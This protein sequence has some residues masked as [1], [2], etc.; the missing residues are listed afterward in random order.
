MTRVPLTFGDPQSS[1]K[2]DCDAIL[3]AADV[4][5]RPFLAGLTISTHLPRESPQGR[6]L[7]VRS[8]PW[9]DNQS[10]VT[11]ANLLRLVAWDPDP[12]VAWD[13]ASY[14][15]GHLIARPGDVDVVS[16]GYDGGPTRAVDPDYDSP[17]AAFTLRARMRAAIL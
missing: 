17:I 7:V 1:A 5:V 2:L 6:L 13:I 12:D 11:A 15:H 8:G 3:A 10:N 4:A 9:V 14:F 16:Y